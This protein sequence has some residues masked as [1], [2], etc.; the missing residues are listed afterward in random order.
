M[1]LILL[2]MWVFLVFLVQGQKNTV[3]EMV[4]ESYQQLKK[5]P[6]TLFKDTTAT[7]KYLSEFQEFAFRKGYL[8]AS[9]DSVV[10]TPIGYKAY[11]SLGERFESA[12]LTL[13]AN[14]LNVVK[15]HGKLSE[16]LLSHAPV[17]PGEFAAILLQVEDAF[18]NA[19][20]PF[21]SVS[22]EDVSI[23]QSHIEARI[24]V[25]RGPY[26]TWQQIHI[27]GDSAISEKYVSNLIGIQSGDFFRESDLR[28]VGSR[29]RQVNFIREIKPAEVLFTKEGA[30]L[31]VYLESRPVSSV[32]GIV[33]LQPD[34]AT[35][36]LTV[37]GELNLKLINVLK[38]GELLDLDW[39]SIQP[40]TQFLKARLNY[41][42]LFRTPFGIDGNFQLYKRDSTFLELVSTAG[43]NY[44]LKGG[45]YIKVFYQNNSSNLLSGAGSSTTFGTNLASVRSNSYG[46]AFYRRQLDYIPNPSQGLVFNIESS[47]GSRKSRV[48]DTSTV[49]SSTVYR[50]S[51]EVESYLPLSRRH[52]L[53]LK[54]NSRFYYAPVIYANE[55]Y[56]FGGLQSQ[57]GFN[58]EELFSTASTTFTVEYRFLVDQNSHAFAFFDQSWY[59]NTS[60]GYTN[61]LPYGFGL[62]FSFGTNFGIFS[63]SYALGKQFDNPV[64]LRNG[65]IH[66]GYIAYF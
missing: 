20:Y 61:D 40:Q 32:N 25:N 1:R 49:V 23:S 11:F 10:R 27:R 43:V 6:E 56:R 8:L 53:K 39:R 28:G 2:V 9:F 42:F 21:S 59:E 17:S 5:H 48:S 26:V 29:L 35:T 30:E 62:G 14:D 45:N 36:R 55:V 7:L 15:K 18:L 58:E 44:F 19:G 33:G 34:P 47:I 38:R 64:L 66:F 54:N 63:I 24:A 57:R 65:K 22:L 51:I 46:V 13:D 50:G 12:N 52:V 60:N 41:P 37:T 4:G 3:L 31:F 16:K